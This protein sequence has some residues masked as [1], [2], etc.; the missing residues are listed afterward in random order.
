MIICLTFCTF[1]I[2]LKNNVYFNHIV[3]I[4]YTIYKRLQG[5]GRGVGRFRGRFQENICKADT[6]IKRTPFRAP[7][8]SAL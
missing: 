3:W 8:L 4:D 6:S 5:V 7:Q 1:G 2:F